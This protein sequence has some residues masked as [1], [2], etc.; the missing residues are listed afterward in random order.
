MGRIDKNK[1]KKEEQKKTNCMIIKEWVSIMVTAIIIAAI[2]VQF[3]RPT[4]V[5]GLSMYSTLNDRDY[6]IINT[7]KY[8]VS[9]PKRGEIIIFDTD[10]PIDGFSD[11]SIETR[12]IIRRAVDFILHDDSRGKDLVKRV[13]GVEGDHIQIEN[14]TVKING[15]EIYEPYLDEG[16]V[17]EGNIDITVPKNKLFVMG[18]NRV[19]SRDSRSQEV[20]LVDKKDVIGHVMLR[21][22]PVSDFGSVD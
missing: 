2:A 15:K 11:L 18:D 4:R 5:D 13:I 12:G 8:K 16:I 3:I 1:Q 17:T 10:M 20:G 19:N 22:L 7:M 6:L 14:G 9:N 21:L